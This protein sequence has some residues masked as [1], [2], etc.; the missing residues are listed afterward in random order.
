MSSR[1]QIGCLVEGAQ[2]V[3]EGPWLPLRW[4]C[5]SYRPSPIVPS[6]DGS[7]HDETLIGR[8]SY[9]LQTN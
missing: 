4:A 5:L 9:D 7:W 2:L 8:G 1:L 3:A 6:A